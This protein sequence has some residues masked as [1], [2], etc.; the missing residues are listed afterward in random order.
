M[1]QSIILAAVMLVIG[2]AIGYSLAP[3]SSSHQA[4]IETAL[5]NN[6]S[7][8]ICLSD[9]NQA[10]LTA[11]LSKAALQ[12][13]P[14]SNENA[15][16]FFAPGSEPTPA[17]SYTAMLEQFNYDDQQRFQQLNQALMGMFEFDEPRAYAILL[18]QGM[19]TVEELNVLFD[20]PLQEQLE[21]LMVSREIAMENNNGES[22]VRQA[23]ERHAALLANRALDE[24]L[25]EYRYYNP[26]YQ[27]GPIA[28]LNDKDWPSHLKELYRKAWILYGVNGSSRLATARI[29]HFRF[30]QVFTSNLSLDEDVA[31]VS[32]IAALAQIGKRIYSDKVYEHFAKQQNWSN[33]E[34]AIYSSIGAAIQ[35]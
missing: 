6:T 28:D 34:Y 5:A 11:A 32:Q 27:D 33:R 14:V 35:R 22:E 3:K 7:R 13:P 18:A 31:K 15:L 2:L 4:T 10:A 20:N 24:L 19:P 16:T 21:T 25:T 23:L 26:E 17:V 12:P 29:A 30:E 8:P 1:K 9:S